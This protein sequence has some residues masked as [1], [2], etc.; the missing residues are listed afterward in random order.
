MDFS[1]RWTGQRD[2]AQVYEYPHDPH[3]PPVM[4]VRV[5]Q[6]KLFA[7]G[8]VHNFPA[9]WYERATAVAYVVAMGATICSQQV[10]NTGDGDAVFFNATAFGDDGASPWLSWR[11]HPLLCLFLHEHDGGLLC[12]E[13]PAARRP[14][15]EAILDAMRSELKARDTGHAVAVLAHLTLLLTELAR[16]A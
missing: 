3:L 16:L 8:Q 10:E 2:N 5:G 4:L 9:L 1:A 6:D 15:F 14:A 11:S 12:V 7:R 13:V